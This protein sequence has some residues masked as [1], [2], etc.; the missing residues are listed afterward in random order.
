MARSPQAAA[1]AFPQSEHGAFFDGVPI[2][3]FEF[4][5]TGQGG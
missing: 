5:L 1:L 3:D 2:E 4:T